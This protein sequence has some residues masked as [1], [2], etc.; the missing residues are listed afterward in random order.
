MGL[1]SLS[2]LAVKWATILSLSNFEHVRRG[3]DQMG[4]GFTIDYVIS[5]YHH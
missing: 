3:S 2:Y 5:A 1:E 4:I